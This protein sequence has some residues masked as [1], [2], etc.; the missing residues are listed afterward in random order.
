MVDFTQCERAWPHTRTFA[1]PFKSLINEWFMEVDG[2]SA[3]TNSA[4][5]ALYLGDDEERRR[6][7]RRGEEDI[8]RREYSIFDMSYMHRLTQ[9]YMAPNKSKQPIY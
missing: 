5:K 7:R 3:M 2:S 8:N 1:W 4:H 9:A 6:R